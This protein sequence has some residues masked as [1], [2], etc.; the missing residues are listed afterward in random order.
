MTLFGAELNLLQI[1]YDCRACVHV[2][3]RTVK[4]GAVSDVFV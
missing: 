4:A 2:G 1:L 3:L